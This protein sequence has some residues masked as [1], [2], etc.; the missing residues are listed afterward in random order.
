MTA[1]GQESLS[2]ASFPR[3][4]FA[5]YQ[6]I[7]ND[8]LLLDGRHGHGPMGGDLVE[9]LDAGVI[10]RLCHRRF[11][12]GA[13]GVILALPP[14]QGGDLQM[15][16]FNADG[17]EPEMCGNGIRCLARFVADQDGDACQRQLHIETLAGV[18]RPTLQADGEVEVDMGEPQLEPSAVPTT[19]GVGCSRAV[20]ERLL[21][22]GEVLEVT[23][24]GMGNPHAV[25]PVAD[26]AQVDWQRLGPILECHPVFPARTNV[27]FLQVL[28]EQRIRL[29]VWERGAG[30]TLACGTGA[31][32]A[33][34]AA[35]LWGRTGR[36]AVV[37]LPG[38]DLTIR[39]C[40]N[41]R[42]LMTGAARWVFNGEVC[43]HNL[44]EPPVAATTGGFGDTTG[45]TVASTTATF[46]VAMGADGRQRPG[47]K[48]SA[49]VMAIDCAQAC[50]Q[51]CRQP[52]NCPSA[53]ARE[54]THRFLAS[55]SLDAMI[56]LASRS[57]AQRIRQ[58]S[59][60]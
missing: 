32:A 45:A 55:S 8:F 31:C 21:V 35:H 9:Q 36:Q 58:R 12:V 18:I 19:L 29:K 24:V 33:L 43:L 44:D 30:P 6:G 15:R 41:N 37:E 50:S 11:G 48:S 52:E 46:T 17:S 7:G 25:V 39:W 1:T 49:G 14:Q 57:L 3:L 60:R 28:N 5:K 40:D 26:L 20:A 54:Q 13:D 47:G 38:G 23:A 16:I 56:D 27:H 4:A 10:R 53:A 22:D 34:V 42:L 51:G 59:D 2:P